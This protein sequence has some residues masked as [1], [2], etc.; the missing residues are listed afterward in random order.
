MWNW[1]PH[2]IKMGVQEKVSEKSERYSR[3]DVVVIGAGNSGLM[4]ACRASKMGLKV[5]C[6]EK[7]N[8]EGGAAQSFVRGRFEFEATLHEIPDFGQGDIRGMLG[9][10]FDE[11]G[12]ELKFLPIHDAFR[13]V[14]AEGKDVKLD[15]T[16][17]HGREEFI[18]FAESVCPGCRK[19]CEIYF[20]CNDIVLKG[21]DDIGNMRGKFEVEEL[22][23]SHPE[24]IKIMS[25]TA[26]EFFRQIGMPQK[27]I[28][29][30]SAY[31]PYQGVDIETIDAGRYIL[32]TCSYFLG[33]AYMPEF[34][35]HEIEAA[36]EKKA[37]EYGCDF[38]FN[39]EVTAIGTEDGA[40]STVTTAD[41]RTVE[42]CA[43]VANVFP[44]IVYGKLLDNKKLIPPFELKKANAREFG[45]R[46]ISVYLGLD[47]SPEELGI[48]DYN[49]FLNS[50]VD[51]VELF[52]KCKEMPAIPEGA[53]D[54]LTCTCTNIVNPDAS[55]EGTTLFSIVSSYLSEAWGTVAPE[56]YPKYKT[57]IADK[58]ISRYEEVMGID[59]RSHIEEIEV[60]TPVTFARYMGTPQGCVYGY[61]AS[62][63]DGMSTRS[64]A[65]VKEMTVPGLFFTGAHGNRLSGF[66]PTYNDGDIIG[67]QVMGYVMGGK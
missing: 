34:R 44:D 2:R 20:D 41:G 47:A 53:A 4:A 24:F 21:M 55:P 8:L 3:Y 10:L 7:H 36:I 50:T 64:L 29:I 54:G 13:Y 45:F 40:V 27:I 51:T 56:D 15:V 14:V 23:K 17:P 52:N 46:A 9:H 12:I 49:V 31:W 22:K 65:G 62:D 66:L 16:V 1:G 48:K 43:V 6:I 30:I 57:M 63:W 19:S 60:A 38:W 33:G 25:L 32:M 58:F 59:L 5:L 11:L 67:K 61:L 35:S 39:T 18:N 42:T 28:D 37:R 26:G